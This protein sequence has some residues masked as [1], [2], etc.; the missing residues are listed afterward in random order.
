M[1]IVFAERKKRRWEQI[2]G[3]TSLWTGKNLDLKQAQM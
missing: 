2:F 3:N 1:A